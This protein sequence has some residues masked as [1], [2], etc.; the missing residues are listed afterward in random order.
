MKNRWIIIA[1]AILVSVGCS[2]I[3]T[4]QDYDPATD[5]QVHQNVWLGIAR[6]NENR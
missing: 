4:S 6:P 3:Q 5:F 1:L 2:G